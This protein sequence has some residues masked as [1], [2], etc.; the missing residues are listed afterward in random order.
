VG[1]TARSRR[2]DDAV[3]IIG[4]RLGLRAHGVTVTAEG[5]EANGEAVVAGTWLR[6]TASSLTR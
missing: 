4:E 3:V 6:S 2:A 1:R 5:L